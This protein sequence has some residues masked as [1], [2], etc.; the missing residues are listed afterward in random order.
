MNQKQEQTRLKKDGANKISH[1]FRKE[2]Q[3]KI[4]QHPCY[5]KNAH[6]YARMHLP[7]APACN[8]QCNYCN[9][10]YDC[11]NESRP[12][13]VS[14]L[15]DPYGALKHFQ[16]IKKRVANLSVV[17]IAGPG[18]AL[19]NP[20]ATFSAL[21]LIKSEDPD[22]Q[23]CISTNGLALIDYI[24]ELV[25]VGVHHLTITINCIDAEIGKKIYPWVFFNHQR[26]RGIEAAETLISRQ[27]AGLE[28]A[29]KAG[30][31]VK[32]NTVLIPGVNDQHIEAVSEKV[33]QLGAMLHNIMPL[34]S[35]PKHGTYFGLTGQRGP[36]EDELNIARGQ[37]GFNIPQMTHCQQCRADAV[38]TLDGGCSSNAEP[39]SI[40]QE[41]QG[42]SYRVAIACTAKDDSDIVQ[43][44]FGYA[45]QFSIYEYSRSKNQFVH[46]ET[47]IASRYCSGARECVDD[48]EYKE[49]LIDSIS[50]CDELVCSRIGISPWRK[51]ELAGVK[52]NV[53]FAFQ[54]TKE[55][56]AQ[57]THRLEE[58][59]GYCG[60]PDK[61]VSNGIC[62]NR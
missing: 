55:A 28:A 61:E 6:Q 21:K 51:L 40:E 46:T 24:E 53:D 39:E 25:E 22:A 54:S 3:D 8:I 43:T 13:V 19:A 16:A 29:S 32:V 60:K 5:S 4:A 50:D 11:S 34:I 62:H 1:F 18:D 12:G 35:D 57:I 59:S 26:L 42:L 17:G 45:D 20:K 38:G 37:S 14:N 36:T 30:M 23:L 47:R 31:L 44:H 2:I 41:E 56:L 48:A 27:L 9:R 15:T 52:P 10:K 58:K 7:V 33:N 49:M